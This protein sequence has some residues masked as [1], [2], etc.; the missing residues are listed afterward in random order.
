MTT[1]VQE[2]REKPPL[3][4][5]LSTRH[6]MAAAQTLDGYV[7]NGDGAFAEL[8]AASVRPKN[9]ILAALPGDVQE[10]L[11][12]HLR[13]VLL[14][15]SDSLH[16]SGGAIDHV[17]FIEAGMVSQVVAASDGSQVEAAVTS[18]EGI[19]G[20]ACVLGMQ[21]SFHRTVVQIPGSA[22]KLPAAILRQECQRNDM[23]RE[24]V[25]RY[26]YLLMVQASQ[27]ALCNRI[28]TIEERLSRW[29]L[30]IRDRIQSNE[31]DLTHEFIAHMLGVRR[32]GVTVSMGILQQAGLIDY[33][34]GH[35]VLCDS[36]KLEICACEC[37]GVIRGYFKMLE[38]WA[39]A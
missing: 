16:E 19:V 20:G 31:L 12:P 14:H 17:Y 25:C 10:R 1:H 34:R 24:L 39:S 13:R 23:L 21:P 35:V 5:P 8:Q 4:A 3:H 2:Q 36:E 33:T 9:R 37:Y 27:S 32:T 28:H 26:L 29:L 11:A 6:L 22:Y 30:T 38:D 18:A 7:P 15:Q